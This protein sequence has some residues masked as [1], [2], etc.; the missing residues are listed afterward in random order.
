[1]KMQNGKTEK[2]LNEDLEKFRNELRA[3]YKR[4]YGKEISF[5]RSWATRFVHWLMC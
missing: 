2:E 5:R 1:M 4:Y 3:E